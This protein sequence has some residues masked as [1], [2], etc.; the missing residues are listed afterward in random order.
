MLMYVRSCLPGY[1]SKLP[2]ESQKCCQLFFFNFSIFALPLCIAKR[3]GSGGEYVCVY[4]H[5][6]THIKLPL[7]W[8]C[9]SEGNLYLSPLFLKQP[10][11]MPPF[12]LKSFHRTNVCVSFRDPPWEPAEGEREHQTWFSTD[13]TQNQSVCKCTPAEP[14]EKK[15]NQ[16]D[17]PGEATFPKLAQGSWRGANS[18]GLVLA[19]ALPSSLLGWPLLLQKVPLFVN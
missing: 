14:K 4:I 7:D 17:P 1:R 18:L 11:Y 16:T 8:F 3:N 12:Y 19:L 15:T 5:I 9:L 2:A 6:Y 13:S 10:T